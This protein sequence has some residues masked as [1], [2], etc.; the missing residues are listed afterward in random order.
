MSVIQRQQALLVAEAWQNLYVNMSYVDFMS[1]TQ[2]N[3]VNAILN[4]VSVNYPDSFNDWITNSEFV[5]KVRTL[6]WLYQ[7]LSYRLDLNVR[8][9]FIQTATRRQSILMLAE[10]VF[11]TPNRVTGASGQLRIASVMTNQPIIDSD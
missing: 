11:Y 9:N 3:L 2:D 7:S 10:N 1:Y 4:Y 8:E 5:I 6:A